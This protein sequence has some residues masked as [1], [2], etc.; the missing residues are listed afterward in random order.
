MK[1]KVTRSGDC[2][3]RRLFGFLLEK[4][5]HTKLDDSLVV[6]DHLGNLSELRRGQIVVRQP[7]IHVVEHVEGFR[8]ELEAD[9]L[10]HRG[11]LQQPEVG[12]EV[13]RSAQDVL[14][15]VTELP[16]GALNELGRVEPL[17]NHLAVRAVVAELCALAANEVRAVG[18]PS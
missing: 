6:I 4:Y 14:A 11:H 15:G 9:P 2:H 7:E 10:V 18:I 12:I 17:L 8:P 1:Q 3:P 16:G 5:L 13:S